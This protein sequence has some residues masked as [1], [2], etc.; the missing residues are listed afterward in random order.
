MNFHLNFLTFRLILLSRI[1]L[2]IN[3]IYKHAE[4]SRNGRMLQV[5]IQ[6]QDSAFEHSYFQYNFFNGKHSRVH[7]HSNIGMQKIKSY[8]LSSSPNW[9]RH[10]SIMLLR[11]YKVPKISFLY[12]ANYYFYWIN[13]IYSS[14][15][16]SSMCLPAHIKNV[17]SLLC[18]SRLYCEHYFYLDFRREF[19]RISVSS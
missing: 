5:K 15:I 1:K 6:C 10:N 8:A 12:R 19:S 11:W 2:I 3:H 7:I 17:T 16:F 13:V 9:C 4:V 18:I 14:I